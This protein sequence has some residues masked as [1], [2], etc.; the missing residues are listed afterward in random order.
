MGD[1]E[2]D[3]RRGEMLD[4]WERA[5]P[6][7]GRRADRV[8]DW[9]LAAS[10]W[11]IEHLK[12]QPGERVL[13]LAAGPGDTGFLAAELVKPGGT[14]LSS[15][16]TEAMLEVARSRA[17]EL[18]IENV[19]FRRLELEWIDLPTASVD[20][21]LCRWGYM[22]ILDPATALLETRRVLRPG[23]RLALA[24]W[25]EAQRNP[26]ATIPSQAL[27]KLGLA[28]PPDPSVPG[29]FALGAPGRLQELLQ[30]AG[31]VDITVEHV[32]LVRENESLDRY[33]EETLDLSQVFADT[34]AGLSDEQRA[35]LRAEIESLA[36]PYALEDGTVR[37]TGRSLVAVAHA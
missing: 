29:P 34:L 35:E 14:L 22:L 15:D 5:A 7:W 4:G 27:V 16:G 8:R 36:A 19:E 1:P 25:D 31:F 11:M 10:A 28:P 32:N 6:G 23:G 9:G 24:V 26:W 30:D 2:V 21:V 17:T 20:A 12:L 18:G 13:E 37:L 3:A 33:L